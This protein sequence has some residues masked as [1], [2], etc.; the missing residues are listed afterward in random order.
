MLGGL[1]TPPKILLDTLEK[2]QNQISV[3]SR[4]SSR[5]DTG[6]DPLLRGALPIRGLSQAASRAASR[7]ASRGASREASRG[8]SRGATRLSPRMSERATSAEFPIPDHMASILNVNAS[9]QPRKQK[10]YPGEDVLNLATATLADAALRTEIVEDLQKAKK[11]TN[12]TAHNLSNHQSTPQAPEGNVY[13]DEFGHAYAYQRS[14]SNGDM[15]LV[16]VHGYHK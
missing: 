14:A 6:I 15:V 7:G 5:G 4:A 11:S 1:P 2:R 12:N 10:Q 16:Q 8:A 3:V 13:F 9:H